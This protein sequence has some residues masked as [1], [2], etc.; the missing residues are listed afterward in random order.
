MYSYP[1][2]SPWLGW[3]IRSIFKAKFYRFSFSETDY[4]TKVKKPSR[5]NYLPLGVFPKSISDMQTTTSR[6]WTRVTMFISYEF[7][8]Y[9]TSAFIMCGCG[10]VFPFLQTRQDVQL[11]LKIVLDSEYII[12][13]NFNQLNRVR[14]KN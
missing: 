6:I 9:T 5:P 11:W 10:C 12:K 14:K 3:D 13:F 7:N 4:H 2:P 1:T 8:H